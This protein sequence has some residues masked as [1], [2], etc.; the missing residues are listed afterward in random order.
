M[1]LSKDIRDEAIAFTK[2]NLV[3]D[4]YTTSFASALRAAG[5]SPS[6]GWFTKQNNGLFN[7]NVI[8]KGGLDVFGISMPDGYSLPN[9]AWFERAG[10]S[11][12]LDW[13]EEWPPNW[14]DFVWPPEPYGRYRSRDCSRSHLTY[15]LI[16]YDIV[17][18][19][20]EAGSDKL[21]LVRTSEDILRAK[22]ERKV[23]IMLDCNCVQIIEDSLELLR[24]LYRLG[25]RDMLLARWG[26]NLVVDS[27]VQTRA[28]SRLTP[29][30]VAVIRG[31]NRIGMLIDLSH[32]SERCFYD[33]LE[34]SKD[35]VIC[36]HSNSRTIF[37][38]PRNL[39][40]DQV[41]ALAEKGGV[42]G[43]MTV[44]IGPG[45]HFRDHKGWDIDDPRFQKW[46]DHCDHIVDLVGVDY[47]GWGSD[48]YGTMIHT[49]AELHK[50]T[51]GLMIRGYSKKEIRKVLGENFLRVFRR[52][53]G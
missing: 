21:L 22:R 23:G 17:M 18:R 39:T 30:G 9:V 47:V 33:V 16:Y 35:P 49:P 11:I 53:V 45:E 15:A 4:I 46:L 34:V 14:Y 51:E 32:T 44:F 7:L 41:I 8:M 29:F 6:P 24:V 43:L 5:I 40:D 42:I 37:N 25:Y 38:H 1:N 12:D 48:G 13:R 36:S 27:W 10:E 52:V 26:R 50:I 19:E 31:L 28:D 20:I 2:E 3:I